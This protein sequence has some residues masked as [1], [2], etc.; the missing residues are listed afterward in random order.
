MNYICTCECYHTAYSDALSLYMHTYRDILQ[1]TIGSYSGQ[2]FEG[3][4]ESRGYELHL[5]GCWPGELFNKF[6]WDQS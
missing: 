6:M 1:V 3:R 2:K 4:P 5:F